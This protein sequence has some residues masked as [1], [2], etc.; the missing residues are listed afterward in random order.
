MI[1]ADGGYAHTVRFGV[2]P[3]VCLG[4]F[5]SL[6]SV[7]RGDFRLLEYPVRKDDTDTGLAVK[8]GLDAGYKRFVIYGGL[9]GNR[10]SHTV[11]NCQ[12]LAGAAEKGCR[13]Y[14]VDGGC[15]MTVIASGQSISFPPGAYSEGSKFSVFSMTSV[16]EGVCI[17][18]AL[19]NIENESFT[20]D[21]PLGAG[22]GFVPGKT[23]EISVKNGNPKR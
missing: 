17:G 6:G 19:Y 22:N 16:S 2:K 12:T 8:Y 14:L 1:A 23:A 3:D 21:Y 20:F 15:F 18:N 9:G 13:A 4:D 7:P 5:D 11:S 10:R